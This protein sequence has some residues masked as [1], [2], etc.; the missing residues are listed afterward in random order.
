[1]NPMEEDPVADEP[2][3]DD[4]EQYIDGPAVAE[5]GGQ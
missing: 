3:D 2:E 1:M 5:Q 4:P